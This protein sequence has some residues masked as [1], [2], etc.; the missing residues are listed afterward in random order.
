MSGEPDLVVMLEALRRSEHNFRAII[1]SSPL[2]TCVASSDRM[3]YANR[4]MLAY[5]G[6]DSPGLVGPTLAELSDEIVHPDDRE[7]TREAF[8]TLLANLERARTSHTT[9]RLD[10]VRLRS[11]DSALRYCDMHGVAILHDGAPALVTY[12]HDHTERRAAADQMRLADRMSALGTLAAGIAHEINNPLTYVIT[13]VELIALEL[14]RMK[15]VAL[16]DSVADVRSGLDRI[17]R[18]VRALRTFSRSDDE[19][20]APIDLIDVLESSIEMANSHLR[21]RGKLARHYQDVPPV[22]GNA[23]RLGQVFLNLLINAAQALDETKHERN[24]VTVGIERAGNE[25]IVS[26][27]DNGGGIPPHVLARVFDAFYTTKPFGVGTGLGLFVCHSIVSAL[28]GTITIESEHGQWTRARV[29]LPLAQIREEPRPALAKPA[30]RR[31]RVLVIDDEPRLLAAVRR[32]LDDHDVLALASGKEALDHLLAGDRFDLIL[33]DLMMPGVSGAELYTR[34]VESA[35]EMAERFVFV[36]G[37]AVTE[38][39]GATVA[40][41]ARPILEKPFS[42]EELQALIARHVPRR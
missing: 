40:A 1:D 19:T 41:S 6:Y 21:H 5:L 25:A 11:R 18:I 14:E 37:G 34:L 30:A 31:V 39:A 10:D 36:T 9:V 29:A 2:P 20:I 23:A 27:H 8:Y 3:L 17:R 32:I 38:A 16:S 28:G 24:Q 26:V 22:R 13:N 4:A 42:A 33:C 35:P 7:R 12:L 15:T